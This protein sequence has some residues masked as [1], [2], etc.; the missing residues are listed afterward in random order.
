LLSPPQV[1]SDFAQGF[2]KEYYPQVWRLF[3]KPAGHDL[4]ACQ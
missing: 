1:I 2:Y 3:V 4:A